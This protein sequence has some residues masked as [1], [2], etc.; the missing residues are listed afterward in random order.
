MCMEMTL[1]M[2]LKKGS[3]NYTWYLTIKSHKQEICS[4]MN[5]YRS[6]WRA[7]NSNTLLKQTARIPNLTQSTLSSTYF[8]GKT[9]TSH[10]QEQNSQ[11][12]M[13][14]G[15]VSTAELSQ[16]LHTGWELQ[17]PSFVFLM[18]ELKKE[19][20]SLANLLLWKVDFHI[21]SKHA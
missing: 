7:E 14:K 19:D 17:I 4:L 5:V 10:V 9:F 18:W 12:A 21:S 15:S 11:A 8:I 6:T 3:F 2:S 13:Q 16:A 20:P 1:Y